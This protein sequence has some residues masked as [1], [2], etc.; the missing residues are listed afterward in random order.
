MA[1]ICET[2]ENS[3]VYRALNQERMGHRPG[4]GRSVAEAVSFAARAATEDLR[5]R[6]I[7]VFTKRGHTARYLSKF[8]PEVP[9]YAFTPA[10]HAREE[11]ALYW[12][13]TPCHT[14]T[15]TNTDVLLR[16]AVERLKQERKVAQGD[17]LV[18]VAGTP[19]GLA[20]TV[21]F[22]KIHQVE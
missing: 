20:G 7:V 1:R 8:R 18:M 10:T 21:N 12:G 14:K 2:T 22:M 11:M 3:A 15:A 16:G 17:L 4:S 19:V 9:V 6:C 13:V 5:V